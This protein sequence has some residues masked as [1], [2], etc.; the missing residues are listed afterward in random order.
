MGI[1]SFLFGGDEAPKTPGPASQVTPQCALD[2]QKAVQRAQQQE[3]RESSFIGD[4]F[5]GSPI[6]NAMASAFR[7]IQV[8][9][10]RCDQ[11]SINS[12]ATFSALAKDI[13]GVER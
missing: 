9:G 6:D 5:L 2:I 10:S 8:N 4:L 7:D 11:N 1:L 12:P 3:N 13:T